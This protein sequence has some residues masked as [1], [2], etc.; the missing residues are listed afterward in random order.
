M[1][2]FRTDA[3]EVTVFLQNARAAVSCGSALCCCVSGSGAESHDEDG[4][5]R[6]A[7][8]GGVACGVA[9]KGEGAVLVRQVHLMLGA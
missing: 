7:G 2:N 1:S 4:A 8:H 6:S 3:Q 5:E 9:G